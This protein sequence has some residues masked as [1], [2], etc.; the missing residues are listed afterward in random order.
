M[1]TTMKILRTTHKIKCTKSHCNIHRMEWINRIKAHQ[2]KVKRWITECSRLRLDGLKKLNFNL[3]RH[4]KDQLHLIC[5]VH[6]R[7]SIR[8]IIKKL[9]WRL[10]ACLTRA[11]QWWLILIL[12]ISKRANIVWISLFPQIFSP[13]P[14]FLCK[15]G[16]KSS[17]SIKTSSTPHH[18][19]DSIH[20]VELSKIFQKR[21][22][23]TPVY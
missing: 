19:Q 8:L 20:K 21:I 15:K 18:R 16:F 10:R 4:S 11:S 1:K 9:R 12:W 13:T 7:A 2:F 22:R 3:K 23:I 5:K 6:L 17:I 14:P